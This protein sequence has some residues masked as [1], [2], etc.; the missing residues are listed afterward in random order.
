MHD[1]GHHRHAELLR[2]LS[3]RLA[4]TAA[5]GGGFR[6]ERAGVVGAGT[7][8]AGAAADWWR[9]FSGAIAR[10]KPPPVSDQETVIDVPGDE[11]PPA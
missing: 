2:A 5:A 3:E 1:R 10:P 9:K 8:R 11:A 6:A 4:L 7:T